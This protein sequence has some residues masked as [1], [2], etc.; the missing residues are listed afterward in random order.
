[1]MPPAGRPTLQE[2]RHHA[3]RQPARTFALLHYTRCPLADLGE[4]NPPPPQHHHLES[5]SASR[6]T[7]TAPREAQANPWPHRHG[8]AK[9]QHRSRGYGTNQPWPEA[10][11]SGHLGP[12]RACRGRP[13]RSCT[14]PPPEPSRLASVAGQPA[15]R[16]RQPARRPAL[17]APKGSKPPPSN[18]SRL[19]QPSPRRKPERRRLTPTASQGTVVDPPPRRYHPSWPPPLPPGHGRH[20]RT[21]Q[22]S[23]AAQAPDPAVAPPDLEAAPPPPRGAGRAGESRRLAR[24]AASARTRRGEGEATP[25]RCLPRGRVGSRRPAQAAVQQ[26][27]AG[28]GG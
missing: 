5:L 3:H 13:T 2:R 14:G 8:D 9:R 4:H 27:V 17:P 11:A 15:C 18:C 28:G 21:E 23:P 7:T 1:M 24:A 10:A 26:R 16:P 19:R 20:P 25:R 6:S 12:T 22:T